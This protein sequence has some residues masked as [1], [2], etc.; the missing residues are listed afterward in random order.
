VVNSKAR[1]LLLLVLLLP[2]CATYFKGTPKERVAR[3]EDWELCQRLADFTFGSESEWLWHVTTEVRER[4]LGTEPRCE[5]VYESRMA[6]L[7]R[8]HE[9]RVGTVITFREAVQQSSTFEDA[10]E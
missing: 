8:R 2:G 10:A 6:V 4:N 9:E 7:Q 5:S 1:A 3:W